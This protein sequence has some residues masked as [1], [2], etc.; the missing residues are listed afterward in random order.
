MEGLFMTGNGPYF[1]SPSV[2]GSDGRGAAQAGSAPSRASCSS[3]RRRATWVI[4]S[5]GCS[6]VRGSGRWD[7]SIKKS[8]KIR[9]RHRVDIGAD[10]INWMNH[11]T[12]YV[13][14][15]DGRRLRNRCTNFNINN[16]TFGQISSMNYNPQS[17]SAFRL[18]PLLVSCIHCRDAEEAQRTLKTR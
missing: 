5:A 14:S 13:S 6:P 12:F 8:F 11:P 4:C 7:M 10:L 18:L 17:H 3:T 9:E 1:V 2:I 15:R 16:P